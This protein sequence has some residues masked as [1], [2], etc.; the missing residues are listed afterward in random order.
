MQSIRHWI[1]LVEALSQNIPTIPGR[2]YIIIADD[3]QGNVGQP[4]A[5]LPKNMPR[6]LWVEKSGQQAQGKAIATSLGFSPIKVAIWDTSILSPQD[7]LMVDFLLKDIM[8]APDPKIPLVAAL[9]AQQS[10]WL[11]PGAAKPQPETLKNLAGQA[12]NYLDQPALPETMVGF[13]RAK[14]TT[15]AV[16]KAQDMLNDNRVQSLM[17]KLAGGGMFLVGIELIPALQ[18][19]ILG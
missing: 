19:A 1:N 15:G 10:L 13:N 12:V 2:N 18:T 6:N 11:S 16:A 5:E 7:K 4:R 14:K 17:A 3:H 9:M 8:V